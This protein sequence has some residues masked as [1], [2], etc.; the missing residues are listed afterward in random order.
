MTEAEI[1]TKLYNLINNYQGYHLQEIYRLLNK[2]LSNT[3]KNNSKKTLTL[4]K[5][6]KLM[7]QD[8]EREEEALDWIEGTLNN[9]LN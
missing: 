8:V 2:E 9:T 3:F 1:K 4:E 5:Q 6:Y 7:S